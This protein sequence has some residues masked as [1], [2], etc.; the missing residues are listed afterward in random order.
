MRDR[1]NIVSNPRTTSNPSKFGDQLFLSHSHNQIETNGFIYPVV[2]VS[3][4]ILFGQLSI[5]SREGLGPRVNFTH[6][7]KIQKIE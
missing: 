6:L 1:V 2:K 7:C 4:F 3:T 5:G